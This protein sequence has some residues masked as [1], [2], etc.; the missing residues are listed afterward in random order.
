MAGD[1]ILKAYSLSS[2]DVRADPLI[3]LSVGRK[4]ALFRKMDVI[5]IKDYNIV[6]QFKTKRNNLFHTGGLFFSSLT[7]EEKEQIMDSGEKAI[8]IMENVTN[9]LGERQTG[10]Y[11][12]LQKEKGNHCDK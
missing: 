11:V 9:L 6:C 1:G 2:Q 10:R 12:Y 7:N 4:L 5:S 3:D 8:A